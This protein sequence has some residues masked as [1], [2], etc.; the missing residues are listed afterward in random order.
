MRICTS[1][2]C[3]SWF[4]S[5]VTTVQIGKVSSFL[6]EFRRVFFERLWGG[7]MVAYGAWSACLG[8]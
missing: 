3:E 8:L 6:W 2:S 4:M 5:R 7:G 1:E